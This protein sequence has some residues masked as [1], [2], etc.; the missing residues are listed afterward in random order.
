MV[1]LFHFC[2]ICSHSLKAYECGWNEAIPPK[3][4]GVDILAIHRNMPSLERECSD[5]VSTVTIFVFSSG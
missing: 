2:L 1:P 3:I 5:A 4:V